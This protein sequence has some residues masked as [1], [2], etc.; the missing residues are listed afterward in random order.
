MS[1]ADD[2]KCCAGLHARLLIRFQKHISNL[3]VLVRIANSKRFTTTLRPQ[4][5]R[6]QALIRG[7]TLP[8]LQCISAICEH[9]DRFPTFQFRVRASHPAQTQP[10][11][12]S[13]KK[14]KKNNNERHPSP[15]QSPKTMSKRTEAFSFLDKVQSQF[16]NDPQKYE[17]FVDI[18]RDLQGDVYVSFFLRLTILHTF[19]LST[20]HF[21]LFPRCR[22]DPREVLLQIAALFNG[23]PD[24][25]VEFNAFLPKG[26]RLQPEG[27]GKKS[28][29]LLIMPGETKIW[30]PNYVAVSV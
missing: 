4:G 25:V 7:D 3:N 22:I 19:L 13:K 1:S 30:P 17:E 18:M 11:H 15:T 26:Y 8:V 6:E 24:L 16:E 20:Q 28:H 14:Q 21:F 29:I 23:Y 9:S 5:G 2:G 27:M 10:T 12:P